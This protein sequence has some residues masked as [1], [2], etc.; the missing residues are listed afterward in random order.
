MD[1]GGTIS[2]D[3]A[4][5]EKNGLKSFGDK[6]CVV[7]PGLSGGSDRGYIKSL[8]LTLLENGYEVAVLHN[9]GVGDTEYTSPAFQNLTS[10]EEFFK[11]LRYIREN[12]GKKMVGVGLS[13][14][15]NLLMKTAA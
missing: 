9:R 7:Y 3:W 8:V 6:L 5:P 11:G 15:G 12:T 10:T 13:M 2:V 4:T 14:G 1:D